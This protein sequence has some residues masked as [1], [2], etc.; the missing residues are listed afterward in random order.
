MN[1]DDIRC[2]EFTSEE[3]GYLFY[4]SYAKCHGFVVRKDEV[5]RKKKHR[6]KTR[7][8][9]EAKLRIRLDYKTSKWKVVSF[10]ETHNHE[11][12]PY[13]YVHLLP[14]YRG[15]T[16]ADKAQ[17][18]RL[19]AYGV[20]MYSN[21]TEDKFE[22]L[23]KRMV[24]KH[25]LI[26]NKWVT[27]TYENRFG[28]VL[29][30]YRNNEMIADFKSMF[31]H[32]VLTTSLQKI[33][34]DAA[35]IFTL[36]IFREVKT[37]IELA[38]ALNVIA[39][40]ENGDKLIFKMNPYGKPGH[41]IQVVYDVANSQFLCDCRLFESRGIPCCHVICALKNENMQSIPSS[42]I[43]NRW[44]KKCK[45]D[46]ISTYQSEDVDT[47]VMK[48]A[49]LGAVDGVFQRL[50]CIVVEKRE[51]F[52]NI[53]EDL[54]KV[55]NK[56]EM[57]RETR[58]TQTNR[59][60]IVKDPPVVKTKG[61]PPKKKYGRKRRR[62]SKCNRPRHISSCP[63]LLGKEQEDHNM[64]D[65][66]SEDNE[67]NGTTPVD[68]DNGGDN[69]LSNSSQRFND[70][71]VNVKLSCSDKVK[72]K[73]P[74]KQQNHSIGT[75]IGAKNEFYPGNYV[76]H[77]IPNYAF[78]HGSSTQPIGMPPQYGGV[79]MYPHGYVPIYP[80]MVMQ[81][82]QN[83]HGGGSWNDLLQQVMNNRI[84]L[85]GKP[86]KHTESMNGEQYIYLA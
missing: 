21:F 59:E 86:N 1:S 54:L 43:L 35:K 25:G 7:V 74:K 28:Q 4:Q 85:G 61:A 63:E 42:L 52:N 71:E 36:E 84:G 27:K 64:H 17:V 9:C 44:T 14:A 40:V 58:A 33:E 55:T 8:S 15:L 23:W 18:D 66:G 72:E 31:T 22:V 56:Y 3:D 6:A 70:N 24:A 51:Y 38:G 19:H 76:L 77:S 16:D 65:S 5:D 13:S 29:R 62:C 41:D 79:P 73:E 75:T 10:V 67:D 12:P 82:P 37:E 57:I 68:E 50:G 81:N 80:N 45:I 60:K 11:L 20:A 2:M 30:E 78:S 48:T 34:S 46:L 47:D 83:A 69:V 49:R 32:P 53:M 39:R 26:R